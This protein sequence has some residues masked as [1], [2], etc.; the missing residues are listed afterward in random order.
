MR[1]SSSL[2]GKKTTKRNTRGAKVK[3]YK[4]LVLEVQHPKKRRF[5]N[6]ERENAEEEIFREKKSQANI[7]EQD[8]SFL[9]ERSSEHPQWYL[10][11]DIH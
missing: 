2:W 11:I 4:Q 1:N 10:K 8:T 6:T 7:P 5:R 3:K 9:I